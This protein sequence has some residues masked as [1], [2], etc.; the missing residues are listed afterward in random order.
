MKITASLVPVPGLDIGQTYLRFHASGF[1]D[2]SLD[3]S[4][5]ASA[6]SRFR[7]L[8]QLAVSVG[9]FQRDRSAPLHRRASLSNCEVF[10]YSDPEDRAERPSVVLPFSVS[11]FV[12]SLSLDESN[13]MV[14]AGLLGQD[15]PP[16]TPE[17]QRAAI[18]RLL[19]DGLLLLDADDTDQSANPIRAALE[20]G[21][22]AATNQ[23]ET[24]AFV[25]ACIGIEA[26][27]GEELDTEA[28]LTRQLADRCAF[29]LGRTR[30]DRSFIRK[31]FSELYRTR[32]KLVHGKAVRLSGA[33]EHQL[34]NAK[35]LLEELVKVGLAS[36]VR[37]V[38]LRK[39]KQGPG[40]HAESA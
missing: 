7:Q 21:F 36:F 38:R 25:Q 22:E 26:L 35:G 30:E 10:V 37:E 9:L 14:P 39:K 1:A 4:A 29:L 11:H 5:V 34:I 13:L 18:A 23:N 27:L 8:I 19:Q 33:D 12:T 31:H 3:S 6:Y 15:R 28:G 24:F 16:T 2:W 20:W 32:S 40:R 17:E